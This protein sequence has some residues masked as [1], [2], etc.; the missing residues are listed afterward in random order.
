MRYVA[1]LDGN[2]GAYGVV[3]PDFPGCSSGGATIDEA[4]ANADE[5]IALWADEMAAQGGDVP[6]PRPV[7]AVLTDPDTAAAIAAG[8]AIILVRI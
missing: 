1:L 2:D 4:V 6:T 3:V 8:D 7:A 5:A